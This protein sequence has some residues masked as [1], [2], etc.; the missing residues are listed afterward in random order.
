MNAK[1]MKEFVESKE[2]SGYARF[3]TTTARTTSSGLSIT[4]DF[5]PQVVIIQLL[6][7][8]SLIIFSSRYTDWGMNIN[9][10]AI[11]AA[12]CTWSGNKFLTSTLNSGISVQVTAFG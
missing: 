8:Y 3:Y 6:D 2:S 1:V 11:S 9:S 7:S 10:G 5:T 12:R 4:F